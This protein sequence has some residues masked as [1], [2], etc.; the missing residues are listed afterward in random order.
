MKLKSPA[1]IFVAVLAVIAMPI[2]L[3]SRPAA[4]I[5]GS[6]RVPV[7]VEL[8]TSEGCSSCPPADALLQKL[9]QQPIPNA[10][11][12]VMSEH[13]D[14]WNH[15]GWKD[16]FSSSAM[17]DRQRAYASQF[18]LDTVYTPQMVVD[19]SQQFSGADAKK[20]QAAITDELLHAKVPVR[21]SAV[22]IDGTRLRA[23]VE[24]GVL[25]PGSGVKTADVFLVVAQNHAESQVLGGENA[26]RHLMHASVV[27]RVARVGKV[28]IGER[29]S[30]QV[31][32]KIDVP[33]D[34]R[35]LRVIAFLQNS[36]SGRVVGAAMEIAP[37]E[38]R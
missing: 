7:L 13:V 30:Q 32:L 34:S 37:G 36:A 27:R 35:N 20:L 28:K 4:N 12:I 31:E 22:S 16:P 1:A 29:F 11:L 18:H 15:D 6:Q 17:T 10:E 38:A 25:D 24:T 2:S 9:D 21:V 19:G 14:Y 26:Q 8:F 33:T 5:E 23:T 3:A